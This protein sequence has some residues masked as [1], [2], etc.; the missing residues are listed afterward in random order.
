MI[1]RKIAIALLIPATLILG[2]FLVAAHAAQAVNW[3][4]Y[5]NQLIQVDFDDGTSIQY[6]YDENGN[7]ISKTY[8]NPLQFYTITVSAGPGGTISPPGLPEGS[9][10]GSVQVISGG[11]CSFTAMP[12]PGNSVAN[13]VVDGNSMG[14][15]AGYTF[16]DVTTAHT[17]S[18]SFA[19]GFPI[20]VSA[21]GGGTVAPNSTTVNPGAG[22]TF[23]ITPNTGFY[24]AS[25]VVDGT[26][27]GTP[28]SYTFTNVLEPHWITVHFQIYTYVITTSV[29]GSGTVTPTSPTV[30]FGASQTFTITPPQGVSIYDVQVDGVSRG[31]IGSYTFTNVTSN[32]TLSAN[33]NAV[34]NQ[35]TAAYYQH[36]GD[37]YLAA[38]DGDILLVQSGTLAEDLTANQNISVT[39]DGG[40][41]SD[42]SAN[43]GTTTLKGAENISAGTVTW[44]NFV[45]SN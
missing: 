3:I 31:A 32:H 7:R 24:I 10:P 45:I 38:Q 18:V 43:P 1:P 2:G 23:T 26:S 25:V 13:L 22:Q 27:V 44:K 21:N 36:L 6:G 4:Y 29:A 19:S 35:R 9:P 42:Y 40:Y 12:D 20:T 28:T 15:I 8:G 16:A 11:A 34:M 5:G 17:I 39:I 41:N 37:A 30:N 33:F 14:A